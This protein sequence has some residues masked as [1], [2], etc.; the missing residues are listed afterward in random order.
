MKLIIL[1]SI[2]SASSLAWANAKLGEKSSREVIKSFE[3]YADEEEMDT[4]ED[5]VE[6]ADT[7][8]FEKP[9]YESDEKMKEL[10][11]SKSHKK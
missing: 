10:E 8:K 3:C 5:Y 1:L 7:G 4:Q 2:L 6:N 11:D 9:N